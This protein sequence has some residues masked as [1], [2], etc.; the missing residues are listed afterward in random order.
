MVSV[1]MNSDFYTVLWL[2]ICN[3][4]QEV[5]DDSCY[6]S[7]VPHEEEQTAEFLVLGPFFPIHGPFLTFDAPLNT[8][9]YEHEG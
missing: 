5:H 4:K 8:Q 1:P 2:R 6:E 7:D 3:I 9:I